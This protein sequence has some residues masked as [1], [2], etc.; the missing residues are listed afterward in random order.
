[1]CLL[2]PS[3]IEKKKYSL[4]LVKCLSRQNNFWF[5]FLYVKT[6]R[7]S[8]CNNFLCLPKKIFH[9]DEFDLPQQKKAK[10]SINIYLPNV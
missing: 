6:P 8:G 7:F 2:L 5:C 3:V 10:S 1:M 4:N 9:D